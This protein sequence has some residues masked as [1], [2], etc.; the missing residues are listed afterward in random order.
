[1]LQKIGDS[2]KG[3]KTL[4]WLILI[5]LAIVFAIWGATGAV[6]LDFI[7]PKKYAAKVDG[8]RGNPTLL[9]GRAFVAHV[10]GRGWVIPHHHD[11]KPRA[12]G[13][14]GDQ[15]VDGRT[16][17]GLHHPGDGLAVDDFRGALAH[18]WRR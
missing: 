6:T 9:A 15:P 14:G 13:T 17:L 12:A 1:M 11:R 10:H 5:P 8:D 2:L 7:G 16:D 4:A 18:D 3:K